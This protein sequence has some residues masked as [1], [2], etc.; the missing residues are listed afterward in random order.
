[1][2]TSEPNTATIDTTPKAATKS[3]SITPRHLGSGGNLLSI[4]LKARS[5]FCLPSDSSF[6]SFQAIKNLEK[7]S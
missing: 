4:R 5:L 3:S 6:H 7:N 2:A 1:M